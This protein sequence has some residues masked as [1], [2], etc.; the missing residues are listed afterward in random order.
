MSSFFLFLGWKIAGKSGQ[1]V[2]CRGQPAAILNPAGQPINE[3]PGC[4]PKKLAR[5]AYFPAKI[6]QLPFSFLPLLK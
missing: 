2:G 6:M 5:Q 4:P 1:S 3:L